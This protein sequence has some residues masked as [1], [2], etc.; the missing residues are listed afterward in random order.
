MSSEDQDRSDISAAPSSPHPSHLPMECIELIVQYLSDD[1]LALHSVLLSNRDLFRMAVPLLYQSPFIL[2]HTSRTW[3]TYSR[4]LRTVHLIRLL[5]ACAV[6]KP[7][8][9]EIAL[10]STLSLSDSSTAL[11][12]A[13]AAILPATTSLKPPSF[14]PSSLTTD[15]LYFYTHQ[16]QIPKW[17][18]IF[19]HLHPNAPKA[20]QSRAAYEAAYANASTNL[21][22]TFYSHY[23]SRIQVLS[24]SPLQLGFIM[25][26]LNRDLNIDTEAD[27]DVDVNKSEEGE[28]RHGLY[29]LER[30]QGIEALGML[31]RLELDFGI[32]NRP[33]RGAEFVS[34]QLGIDASTGQMLHVTDLPLMFV[35]EH[36]RLFPTCPEDTTTNGGTLLQE[37]AFRGSDSMW[38]PI[39]LLTQIQPLKIVDFSAWNSDIPHLENIPSSRLESL[40][41]NTA[42][43]LDFVQVPIPYLMQCTQLQEISMHS[44]VANTFRWAIDL[45][46]SIGEFATE[47]RLRRRRERVVPRVETTE[48]QDAGGEGG[49]NG[50][51]HGLAVA[52]PTQGGM[53][54]VLLQLQ[55]FHQLQ[56][57]PQL[58]S[59]QDQPLHPVVDPTLI[60]KL[61]KIALYGEPQEL[62]PSLEDAAD[63]FRD[64]LEVLSGYEDGY[65]R[66][67]EYIHMAIDWPMPHLTVLDLR[68]R[69]VFFF[70]LRSLRQCP[71]LKVVRLTIESN[72]SAASMVNAVTHSLYERQDVSIFT[73]LHHLEE[74]QL[75]GVAWDIDDLVL[76]TLATHNQSPLRNSLSF[77]SITESPLP[78]KAGLA[79]F[80]NAMEKLKVIRLGTSHMYLMKTLP[81]LINR[82]VHIEINTSD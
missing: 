14:T 78:T 45:Q 42:R 16:K 56:Q 29:W 80:G 9:Q 71:G 82:K 2:L 48:G 73:E 75:T 18:T 17:S 64:S 61:R 41:I 54:N 8:Q 35:Q 68:G 63:A 25:Y 26:K 7:S 76:D 77:F 40:K 27:V 32:A 28:D 53:Q 79:R 58:Q 52:Q 59:D 6:T 38:T 31:K 46:K 11:S 23:P 74:L 43:R 49:M 30:G 60:P 20:N 15:Y 47:A 39:D 12:A 81:D 67:D 24:M 66:K 33:R 57:Q 22:F 37:I 62:I 44:L 50:N 72:I 1:I 70:K 13:K 51:D 34:P 36:Q 55:Q 21:T 19:S 3:S 65:G 4:K 5:H 69:Y 10:D